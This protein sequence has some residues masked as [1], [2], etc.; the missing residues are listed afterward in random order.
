MECPRCHLDLECSTVESVEVDLC[1]QCWGFWLDTGEIEKVQAIAGKSEAIHRRLL[2][3]R[4][5]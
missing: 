4:G 5:V 2:A 1:L 3:K